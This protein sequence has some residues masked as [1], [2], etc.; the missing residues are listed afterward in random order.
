MGNE[1]RL[2]E[3]SCDEQ[4]TD[5][6]NE[7]QVTFRLGRVSGWFNLYHDGKHVATVMNGGKIKVYDDD[8]FVSERKDGWVV[9]R[10]N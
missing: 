7:I 1:T 5:V 10:T 8:Y 9:S 6:T 2:E 3:E 4:T